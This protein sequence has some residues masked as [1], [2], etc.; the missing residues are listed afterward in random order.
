METSIGENEVW[1]RI[2]VVTDHPIVMHRDGGV[3]ARVGRLLGRRR[4]VVALALAAAA[5]VLLADD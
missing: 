5:F 2:E 4:W 1:G 3:R